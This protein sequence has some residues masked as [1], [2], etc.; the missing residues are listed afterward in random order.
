MSGV[1]TGLVRAVVESSVREI[2]GK[3]LT[4]P[5]LLVADS[6]GVMTWCVDVDIGQK[7]IDTFTGDEVLAVLK[8]VAIASGDQSL[9]YADIGAA[10]R[11][12]RTH[13]GRWEISGFSKE[14]PGSY[15]RVP[16]TIGEPGADVIEYELGTPIDITLSSRVL[17]YD[18]LADYGGGYGR[19]PYGAV[20]VFRG[21]TLLEIR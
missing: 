13:S 9:L 17:A 6:T 20:G 2:D 19:I 4:R 16:V 15:I 1:V 11:C 10:V 14:L 7:A 21:E 5:T 18:E 3:T 12:R 8:N